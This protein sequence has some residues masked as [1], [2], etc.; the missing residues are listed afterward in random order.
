MK[1]IISTLLVCFALSCFAAAQ[2]GPFTPNAAVN[3]NI[4]PSSPV[5]GADITV[6]VY[7]NLT[8][9]ANGSSTAAALGGFC[10][11]I[12]FDNSRMTLKT[13]V[14]GGATE[15]GDLTYT[16]LPR[17]NARGFVT[18]VNANTS[19]GVPVGNIHIATLTFTLTEAGRS[20]FNVNS[21]RTEH[22]GSL[23]STYTTGGGPALIAYNDQAS[24]LTI[25][26]GSANYH[27]IFPAFQSNSGDYMS[28][29]LVNE[30]ISN[31]ALTF[32]GYSP[33]GTLHSA[34]GM[35]NPNSPDAL[36]VNGQ[37]FNMLPLAF[38][39][40]DGE[41]GISQ[42][43]L[44]VETPVHNMSGFFILG[45]L[46]G[47]T[48]T[49]LDGTDV[50]HV[51]TNHMIFPL[52]YKNAGRDTKVTIVNPGTSD[53]VGTFKI[54][55]A[56]GTQHS[57]NPVTIP[58]KG[59]YE[60]SYPSSTLTGD[61]YFDF[62]A[63]SGAVAGL[64]VFGNA[65]SLA[66]LAGVDAANPS[67]ILYCPAIATGLIGGIR[68]A[69]YFNLV[70]PSAT[71]T[72]NV[73]FRL[74]N[75]TGTEIVSAVSRTI[76]A[77]QQLFTTAWE[78]FGLTNPATATDGTQGYVKVESDLALVGNLVFGDSDPVNGAFLSS[79]PFMSTCSAK[80]DISLDFVAIGAIG[81]STYYTGITAVNPSSERTATVT[82][83][84]YTAAS[85]QVAQRT[86]TIPPKNRYT[87]LV[88]LI[89]TPF[90]VNQF[91]GFVK[92]TSD[93]E[94]Y[95]FMMFGDYGFNFLAAVPVR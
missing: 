5:V 80:R 45:H 8:G 34:S 1:K 30:G 19:S 58:A 43:W 12:A 66:T 60:A 87:S 62:T 47:A 15:F 83:T 17:A 84:L 4:T 36:I 38:G 79:L 35:V 71:T 91:G 14:K 85:A 88:N 11:P 29:T 72:A 86:L 28:F 31:A 16:D 53:A 82:I 76:P 24:L 68:W 27:L 92:V 20:A 26:P 18:L 49:Y 73:T 89:D 21:A 52:L 6:Q 93:I 33:T 95:S 2:A 46:E 61:G 77:G 65:N 90:N 69:S 7:V 40:T 57:S 42:G 41:L 94:V 54:M 50:S 75:D 9:V 70:N 37:Y 78:L 48:S 67:N 25:T 64:E 32:R 10:V 3:L 63:S 55:N 44:D 59:T 51:T 74:Y 22:E 23:A 13:V 39:K 81:S 56:N